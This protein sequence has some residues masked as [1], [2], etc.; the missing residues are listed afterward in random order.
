MSELIQKHDNRA[1]IRWKLLTGASAAVLIASA[2]GTGEVLAADSDTSRPQVWIELGAQLERANGGDSAFAPSFFGDLAPSL[3]SPAAIVNELPWAFGP[4]ATVTF[5]PKDSDWLFSAGIRFGRSSDQRS[6]QPKTA[7][8]SSH[9]VRK[10]FTK[11]PHYTFWGKC[12]HTTDVPAYKANF[13]DVESKHQ[14][15]HLLLDFKAGKDVGLGLFGQDSSSVVSA[16]V[17]YAQFTTK[18]NISV[19]ARTDFHQYNAF[20]LPTYVLYYPQIL[21]QHPQKYWPAHSFRTYSMTA[22]S[23]RS[24]QGIGPSLSWDASATLA[25]NPDSSELT[26]D[27]DVNA[28]LL[29]GRQKSKTHHQASGNQYYQYYSYARKITASG[30]TSLY[31]HPRVQHTRSRRVT[32][33]NLGGMAGFSIKWPNAKISIGYRADYFFGAMDGGWDTYKKQDRSFVGPFASISI[34]LGD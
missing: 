4:E 15:S 3:G 20:A 21:S 28:A 22:G 19:K 24:F 30:Y 1:T 8:H 33:P 16:G 5:Q 12:C 6:T 34:G 32:V 23:A 7:P 26:F 27:W 17:R 14:A 31:K 11:D 29:F 9:T 25:G 10:Y 18:S 13:F 2:C